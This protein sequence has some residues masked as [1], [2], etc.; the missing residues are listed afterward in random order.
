MLVGVQEERKRVVM[1]RFEKWR[2][3]RRMCVCSLDSECGEREL[4]GE[5]GG[6]GGMSIV[7]FGGDDFEDWDS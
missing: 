4:D 6:L 3:R 7:T 1:G 5:R 2:V